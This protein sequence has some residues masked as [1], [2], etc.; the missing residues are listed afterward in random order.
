MFLRN[1]CL[2]SVLGLCV[3]LAPWQAARA[4]EPTD[5]VPQAA[6]DRYAEAQDLDSQGK[7][8]EAIDA[9]EDAIRLGMQASPRYLRR[10]ASVIQ[11]PRTPGKKSPANATS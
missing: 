11:L 6:R 1:N 8:R 9:Y 5:P 2:L 3:L 7:T 4:E 10:K